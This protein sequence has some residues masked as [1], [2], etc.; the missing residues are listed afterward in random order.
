M[1]NRIIKQAEKI[2]ERMTLSE[3]IGQVTQIPISEEDIDT[4]R[5]KIRKY[6]PGSVVLCGSAF[7]GNEEQRNV[8]RRFLDLLQRE[9]LRSDC[10]GIPLMFGRDVVH[11]HKVAFPIPLTMVA[12]FDFELIRKCYDAI[13]LEAAADGINWSF[14][15]MLDYCREPRWGRIV[16]GPGEDPFIGAC[17]AEAAVKGFQTEDPANEG[18]VAACAKHFIGYGASEGGRD[19]SHT[20][21][22]EYQLQN[23]YSE[24]FR[25]AVNADVLTVMSSFNELNGIPVSGNR[26]LLTDILRGQFGFEGFVVSDWDAIMQMARFAGYAKDIPDAAN[27]AISAGIDMDMACNSY[28]NCLERLIKTGQL[29]E[30]ILDEA[31]LRILCVKLKLGLFENPYSPD[32]SYSVEEHLNLAERLAS[33]SVVLLKNRNGILPVSGNVAVKL[34]GP[35]ADNATELVG[36]W[37][38]DWDPS[39]IN[40]IGQAIKNKM[41]EVKVMPL[42]NSRAYRQNDMEKAD[43]VIAVLGEDRCMTGEANS[44]SSLCIPAEQRALLNGLRKSKIPVIGVL[45]FARPIVLGEDIDLFDAVLYAGHG[46]SRASEAIVDILFG[47][48]EPQGRLPFTVAY[49]QGQLPLYYNCFPGARPVNGYYGEIDP[50]FCN[51]ADCPDKPLYPFGYGLSYTEFSYSEISCKTPSKSLSELRRGEKFKLE[52]TATDIG[53]RKGTAVC[54]MYVHDICASRV[55]P[56]RELKGICRIDL[57]AGESRES[58]FFVGCDELGFYTENGEFRVEPGEFDIYIGENSQT[59]NKFRIILTGESF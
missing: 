50:W 18:T 15:P 23:R 14:A 45:C 28:F 3:K 47:I 22:P 40:S 34:C 29:S 6:K 33:E 58:S 19:Y 16:E 48:T 30:N 36:T 44:V 53:K 7:A 59:E 54:Q 52:I 31:V 2:L 11:G 1:E 5:D 13:R 4:A 41:P 21:I 55:R 8:G 37:S 46:G 26:Y 9:A 25:A 35:Y 32:I 49:S 17:F 56:L 43:F 12:S 39:L 20:E 27:I 24:A 57:K 51:Y 10:C 42:S 38:L